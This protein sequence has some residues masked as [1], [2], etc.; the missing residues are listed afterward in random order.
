M[1]RDPNQ[2]LA[3]VFAV[4]DATNEVGPVAGKA[5]YKVIAGCNDGQV[6]DYF[7]GKKIDIFARS[8][9]LIVTPNDANNALE[10]DRDQ[11]HYAVRTNGKTVVVQGL[12]GQ[13]PVLYGYF[14]KE[15]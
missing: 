8:Q 3:G 5:F 1:R 6:P 15:N 13:Q 7:D 10:F 9:F 12:S 14:Y 11:L 2:G 4:Y